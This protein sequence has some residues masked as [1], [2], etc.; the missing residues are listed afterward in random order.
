MPEAPT[1]LHLKLYTCWR[2][3]SVFIPPFQQCR[4]KRHPWIQGV[5]WVDK[6][7][8]GFREREGVNSF[9]YRGRARGRVKGKVKGRVKGRVGKEEDTSKEILRGVVFP[10]SQKSPR[11]EKYCPM[12]TLCSVRIQYMS[13]L[14]SKHIRDHPNSLQSA[15]YDHIPCVSKLTRIIICKRLPPPLR[16]SSQWTGDPHASAIL[17]IST[18]SQRHVTSSRSAVL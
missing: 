2:P 13:S 9:T 18:F 15:Q 12:Y 14:G 4:N 5:G 10:C 1:C 7:E 3:L 6:S 17:T 11:E 8:N 16:V